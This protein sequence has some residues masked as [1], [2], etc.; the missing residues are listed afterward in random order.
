M[1]G[2]ST[3]AVLRAEKLV[4]EAIDDKQHDI[5]SRLDA[6]RR[7]CS[8]RRIAEG[9]ATAP[10]DDARHQVDDAVAFIVRNCHAAEVQ[11][12]EMSGVVVETFQH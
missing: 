2:E 7:Q 12:V 9:L 5:A 1:L 10:G 6:L 8:E 11:L 3:A 4:T